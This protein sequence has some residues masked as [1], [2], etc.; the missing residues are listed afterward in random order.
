MPSEDTPVNPRSS[1]DA[2]NWWAKQTG[3]RITDSFRVI[4]DDALVVPQQQHPF[5]MVDKRPSYPMNKALSPLTA[6]E[7]ELLPYRR[8]MQPSFYNGNGSGSNN[9][10]TKPSVLSPLCDSRII[11]RGILQH[12]MF[13]MEGEHIRFKSV[14]SRNEYRLLQINRALAI[15]MAKR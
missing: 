11:E 15:H 6:K 8:Q 1:I 10:S 13:E 2:R 5:L 7:L 3:K 9:R 4:K 14:A 12:E